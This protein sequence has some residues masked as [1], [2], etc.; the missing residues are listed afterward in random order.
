SLA[1]FT[2]ANCSIASSCSP[3]ARTDL[4]SIAP[5]CCLIPLFRLLS[6]TSS[7]LR[8][9]RPDCSQAF[10]SKALSLQHALR[11]QRIGEGIKGNHAKSVSAL[12]GSFRHAIYD[13]GLLILSYRHPSRRLDTAHA[14]RAIVTHTGHQNSDA[15]GAKFFRQTFE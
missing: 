2:G 11:Q 10:R 1:R 6:P 4:W 9:Q 5:E 7:Y 3:L 14:F 8:H 12:N 15:F 13:A